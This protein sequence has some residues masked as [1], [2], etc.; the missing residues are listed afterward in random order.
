M[1]VHFIWVIINAYVFLHNIYNNC[2]KYILIYKQ[3]L[4]LCLARC[5]VFFK[6]FCKK[7]HHTFIPSLCTKMKI[8]KHIHTH[9]WKKM[10]FSKIPTL[11]AHINT[12]SHVCNITYMQVLACATALSSRR[13]TVAFA[14]NYALLIEFLIIHNHLVACLVSRMSDFCL[15][16]VHTYLRLCVCNVR[17]KVILII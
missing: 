7:A 15:R 16:Q 2:L 6:S 17:I 13:T 11:P 12:H 9:T 5:M 14:T 10:Y 3:M 1:Y 8:N 4:L